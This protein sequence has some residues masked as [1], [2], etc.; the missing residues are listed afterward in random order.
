MAKKVARVAAGTAAAGVDE[1]PHERDAAKSL[2]NGGASTV[3]VYYN[4]LTYSQRGYAPLPSPRAPCI[5][6]TQAEGYSA[7]AGM[8]Q[9]SLLAASDRSY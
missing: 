3:L 2:W 4:A 1:A 6:A 8:L 5:A 7:E 9:E